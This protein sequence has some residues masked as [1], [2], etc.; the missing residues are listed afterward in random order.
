MKVSNLLIAGA[1]VGM[2][3]SLYPRW[4]WG[5]AVLLVI[6]VAMMFVVHTE[7]SDPARTPDPFDG[8]LYFFEPL[9]PSMAAISAFS[10]G[11][12]VRAWIVSRRTRDV[13]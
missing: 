8:L 13:E 3:A 5:C 9:W 7:L 11:R 2:V 12:A 10:L 6:P 1:F 4:R